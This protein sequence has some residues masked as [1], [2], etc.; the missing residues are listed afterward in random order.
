MVFFGT[1]RTINIHNVDLLPNQNDF[2]I[3]GLWSVVAYFVV[4]ITLA[5]FNSVVKKFVPA[6]VVI[7]IAGTLLFICSFF[8]VAFWN[9]VRNYVPDSPFP[10]PYPD[11]MQT[12]ASAVFISVLMSV[13]AVFVSY[14]A[15]GAYTHRDRGTGLHIE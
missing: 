12:I 6:W 10:K 8:F 4:G 1:I 7:P 2:L 3:S 11:L 13:I 14:V 15:F 9:R 5:K